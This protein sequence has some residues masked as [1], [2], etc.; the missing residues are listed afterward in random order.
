MDLRRINLDE[1]ARQEVRLLLVV[2]LES[3]GVARLEQRL[4]CLDDRSG[5][6]H[7]SLHPRR[8]PG[9]A[10]GLL[11][12]AARPTVRLSGGLNGSIHLT[13]PGKSNIP[14]APAGQLGTEL[15]MDRSP[16]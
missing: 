8:E 6:Q 7:T 13:P 11:R 15:D 10:R 4:Q 14:S 1:R 5:L 3:H 9:Q 16:F 2:T 12:P